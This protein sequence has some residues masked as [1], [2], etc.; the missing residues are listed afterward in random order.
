MSTQ[1]SIYADYFTCERLKT[2]EVKVGSVIIG[3]DRPIVIQSM[4]NTNTLDTKATV[5]Q[6]IRII[7][8]GGELVRITAQ[9]VGEA[10]NLKNIKAEL[11]A[12]GYHTP[13]S[14]DIH[15]NPKAAEIAAQYVEKVRI[16]PGNYSE[17]NA[18]SDYTEEEYQL[19]LSKT[20]T[21][22]KQLIVLCKKHS[23]AIRIGVNHGSLS[24]RILSKYGNTA[25]GMVESALE[26]VRLFEEVQFYDLIISL[27]SSHVL[28]MVHANRLLAARMLQNGRIYP[29]HLGVT[30]AGN[31]IEGRQKSIAG[32]ASLLND[33]IGDTVRI[34]LTEAPENEI[35]IAKKLLE[36]MRQKEQ[37]IRLE[38]LKVWFN[39]YKIHKRISA[40][41]ENI[42]GKN[43]AVVILSAIT[44]SNTC[45]E[46]NSLSGDDSPQED[47]LYIGNDKPVEFDSDK[48]YIQ[49][50]SVWE[51]TH[52]NCYPLLNIDD[53]HNRNLLS[54][55]TIFLQL[56]LTEL[57]LMQNL[58]S[59]R[60]MPKAVFVLSVE[61]EKP[62][63][64]WR[65]AF[66]CLHIGQINNPVI[67]YR[68][69]ELYH[70]EDLMLEATKIYS[71]LLLDGLGDGIWMQN[72]GCLHFENLKKVAF[73]ILQACR[74][75]LTQTEY[76]ACPSCGRTLFNIEE[77][78]DEI[79]K[80]TKHLKHLK[81]AIMGCIVNGLGEMADA[82]YGYVGSGAGKVNLYKGITL[83][84]KNIAEENASE[85]LI[86]LIKAE[87]DW[88]D[89]GE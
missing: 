86:N 54:S 36:S 27:K 31:G 58:E 81:I 24:N 19:A 89:S 42:G 10:E 3:G 45:K 9:G 4:T 33:G 62:I 84:H 37:N 43:Q 25:L 18:K 70:G 49:D 40:S 83:K 6:C 8:A 41:V 44:E 14:A 53:F 48:Q 16:N 23:T 50:I 85:A 11:V 88:K 82:D 57:Y 61:T 59:L 5:E 47:F 65:K 72:T 71:A 32:I 79:R 56:S 21:K 74:L 64:E 1:K 26:F 55:Q 28:T 35:P 29:I 66:Y 38:P 51:N 87:G 63:A 69:F 39:P 30:E 7:E 75:R 17:K 13:L 73:G 76:I 15:F 12:R 2:R 77:R 22:L 60:K 78:L 80:K 68:K 46:S 67:L 34:S 20:A 52:P